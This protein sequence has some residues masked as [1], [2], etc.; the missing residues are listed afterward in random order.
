MADLRYQIL[1]K[2]RCLPGF[3][4]VTVRARLAG[5]LKLAA[6]QIEAMF[7][8]RPVALKRGLTAEQAEGYLARLNRLGLDVAKA[9]DPRSP[10]PQVQTP[11][12]APADSET[13]PASPAAESMLRCYR[14]GKPVTQPGFCTDCQAKTPL[15]AP[16]KAAGETVEEAFEYPEARIF[17]L[18]LDGRLGCLRYTIWMTLAL[19][20]A[21]LSGASLIGDALLRGMPAGGFSVKM[22][23]VLVLYLGVLMLSLRLA[24]LRLH[25]L[26]RGAGWLLGFIAVFAALLALGGDG[27][28]LARTQL[29][30]GVLL[31]TIL[32]GPRSDNAFGPPDD[33]VR[34]AWMDVGPRIGRL[35]YFGLAMLTILTLEALGIFL[36]KHLLASAQFGGVASVTRASIS[37]M[38]VLPSVFALTLAAA[39]RLMT[40]RLN[41]IGRSGI[42]IAV[43][44]GALLLLHP[45][46][47]SRFN[48]FSAGDLSFGLDLLLGLAACVGLAL[49][50]GQ[51]GAN[52]YG[53]PERLTSTRWLWLGLASVV[54]SLALASWMQALKQ[55]VMQAMAHRDSAAP[56]TASGSS[57][58]E[59]MASQGWVVIMY[60]DSCP[61]C[62][63]VAKALAPV[64]DE[65]T[66]SFCKVGQKG[67]YGLAC[68]N[69]L[70]TEF[71]QGAP[72]PAM[73][74]S[75]GKP[76]N[77]GLEREIKAAI[78][79]G[80]ITRCD[81]PISPPPTRERRVHDL[82]R[83]G[84]TGLPPV[85]LYTRLGSEDSDRARDWLERQR[86]PFREC[87]VDRPL[88][89]SLA[90]AQQLRTHE[91]PEVMIG[92][93][94]LSSTSS[95]SLDQAFGL[96]TQ[97]Q[98][99]APTP[100]LPKL[101]LFA[102]GLVAVFYASARFVRRV[103][104][105]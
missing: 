98:P 36:I 16:E 105:G 74:R 39:L 76:V 50:P 61:E 97:Q 34:L 37:A 3:D 63:G 80:S 101:I 23:A 30:W 45:V 73:V 22:G 56:Q 18:S 33:P 32:S 81:R 26:N 13:E 14:C 79:D 19:V 12:T 27:L 42:W 9:P 86:I 90:T 7:Q 35:R 41:D 64:R 72:L 69:L 46:L 92:D 4:E 47:G 6:P 57:V 104:Q 99:G 84:T 71:Y 70:Q 15:A 103:M 66:L 85:M 82:P 88:G 8:G 59:R 20:I 5:Q 78:A 25:D 77:Q 48:I 65:I 68:R 100:S 2:G 10:A 44:F 21:Q 24:V 17:G 54:L 62:E 75:C 60:E 38:S 91:L 93:Y 52:R 31:L 83:L 58:A 96:D 87:N 102:A 49:V 40:L 1:F 55:D 51:E 43:G 94:R 53:E 28:A 67:P 11:S 95:Q 89:C 29:F